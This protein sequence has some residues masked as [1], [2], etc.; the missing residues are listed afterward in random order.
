MFKAMILLTR[1]DDMTPEVFAEWLLGEHA[2]LAARLPGLRRLVYNLVETGRDESGV[3]GIA[4]LWFDSRAALEGAYATEIGAA[5]AAD[6]LAHVRSRVRVLVA[7]H[8][9][10]VAGAG[11][12]AS[13]SPPA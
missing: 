1:R 11:P 9:V 12:E 6:S 13:G 5:V 4:E 7:E 8:P 2:P 10:V 3:D